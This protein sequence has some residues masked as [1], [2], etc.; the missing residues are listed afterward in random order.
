MLYAEWIN[1]QGKGVFETMNE[2]YE[3]QW[4]GDHDPIDVDLAYQSLYS[5]RRVP[6]NIEVLAVEE[7]ANML[8]LLYNDIWEHMSSQYVN[9]DLSHSSRLEIDQTIDNTQ[10][11]NSNISGVN[12]VSAFDSNSLIDT[13]Q[14]ESEGDINRQGSNSLNRIEQRSNPQMFFQNLSQLR[15]HS[16]FKQIFNDVASVVSLSIH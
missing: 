5:M 1:K 3:C 13:D 16:L 14:S 7:V 6:K 10:S 15:S 4:L 12:R 11:E 2:L 9:I 8:H